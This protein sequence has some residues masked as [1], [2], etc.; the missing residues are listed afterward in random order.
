LAQPSHITELES[1]YAAFSGAPGNVLY[2]IWN[3]SGLAAP[4]T[5]AASGNLGAYTPNPSDSSAVTHP[6]DYGHL[7][8]VDVR[9]P[10]GDYYLTI[11][12]AAAAGQTAWIGWFT[13]GMQQDPALEQSF[14]WR[15]AAYP[16]PGFQP[17]TYTGAHDQL[18]NLSDVYNPAFTLY[19]TPILA[20]D[21]DGNGT[22]GPEDYSVWK[23]SFGSTENLAADGNSDGIVDAADYGVWRH[24]L[25]QAAGSGAALP[26]A[27]SLPVGVPEPRAAILLGI[28]TLALGMAIKRRYL[29]E[30]G[31]QLAAV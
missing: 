25:G 17:Y 6:Y 4:T 28:G 31:G 7:Q 26:S 12:G 3:R 8:A 21:Y 22:V 1:Y 30:F 18:W 27:G 19:G 15:S 5:I 13:G 14:M 11:Y 16:S 23:S 10:E 20:G 29:E 9:L 2:T 24:Y